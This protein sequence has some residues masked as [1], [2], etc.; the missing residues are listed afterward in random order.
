MRQLLTQFVKYPIYANIVIV[1]LVI[2][3]FI[4]ISN[5]KMAFFPEVE[6]RYISV[7]VYYPG[8]SPQEIEEGITSRI[9]E[10]IR[11]LVGIKEITSTSLENRSNVTI[12]TTGEYPVD[13]V[14]TE[15]KNAVDGISSLPSAAERPL[16]SKRR[17]RSR[18]LTLSLTA[19]EGGEVGLQTLKT[20]AQQVEEDLLR[21][22]VV[23]QLDISGYPAL[24]ISVEIS[25]ENL[26][27]YNLTFSQIAQAISNNNRDLSGGEIRSSKEELLIRLRSRSSDPNKIGSIVV[28]SSGNGKNVYLRDVATVEKKFANTAYKSLRQGKLA[29]SIRVEKLPEEDLQ[30]ID[31]YCRNYIKTFNEKNQGIELQLVSSFL[32]MLKARLDML[33]SNG[34]VGLI[35]VII[36]LALFLS[37]RLSLWVSWGI[38]SAFLAMFIMANLMGVTINMISLFGMIL[39]IGI[40][41]DDGIVIGENIYVHFENGKSPKRAAIDGTM[42]VMPAVVTSISTTIVA[43]S[44]LLF[45]SGRMEFMYEMALVVILCLSF[46]LIE[47]FF[48]LPAHLASHH[49]LSQKSLE[50]KNKGLRKYLQNGFTFL[51]EN[52]YGKFLTYILSW[53]YIV[54]VV[55]IVFILITIGLLSA[56]IITTTFFPAVDSDTFEINIAFT[57][58]TGEETTMKYL[59]RFEQ[60][61]WDLNEELKSDNPVKI[62]DETII[63][64]TGDSIPYIERTHLRL[65]T[66]FSGVENG[67][68]AG[69]IR[70]YPRDMEGTPIG[71]GLALARLL[72]SRIGNIP[73][74]KKFSVAGGNRWGKPVSISV[75]SNNDEQLAKARKIIIDGLE[76]MP[77][78]KDVMDSNAEGKQ[79]VHLQL[80]P[81]AYAL[82]LSE[83]AVANKVRQ[84]FY[85]EQVQRLQEGRDELRVW[86]RYP[87]SNRQRIGQ[88]EQM[89]IQTPAG[90]YPL[91]E[92]AS[93]DIKRGPV[94]IKR[95]N[96]SRE[97]RVEADVLDA[98]TSV[99][100]ILERVSQTITPLIEQQLPNVQIVNQGQQKSSNEAMQQIRKYFGLAFLVMV[101][102]LIIHFKSFQ[103]PLLILLMLPLALLGAAWGHGLHGKPLS[104]LSVWGMVALSGVIVNDAVVFLAKYNS[105]IREG[106]Q[107]KDAI[108]E[109]GKSRLR[110]I[111]LTTLTTSIGL[112]PL[113]METSFQAQ[114]LIPMAISLAYGVAVGTTLTLVFL[115][116]FILAL[117]D[118]RCYTNYTSK[119]LKNYYNTG[120][121]KAEKP[122]RKSVEVASILKE[123]EVI[124]QEK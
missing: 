25:E 15:V 111:I 101:L 65:G 84:A 47:A 117:N 118:V 46:S 21:S 79:E 54:L 121:W 74:A 23:S 58:G 72:K 5:M 57:P 6:S 91:S 49:V 50:Q 68:H 17:S 106:L 82:G 41:V 30:A 4:S 44:P 36:S 94:S 96:G 42:E 53:R 56:R 63:P 110:P 108:I 45:I 71:S 70:I 109:A 26:L 122:Q 38:P 86:V 116:V 107:V 90:I 52:I 3:G 100:E 113:I 32:D 16:I 60:A 83:M 34:I 104:I 1:V 75:L 20:Y 19:S 40:L 92:L 97:V 9:E 67:A 78:L 89:R 28:A 59:T 8:A 31:E 43:F 7:S 95:Y 103:Q 18:T 80:K 37:F 119:L 11:G 102:I 12:E 77:E 73:E 2:G 55:P 24:E 39:V 51:R 22:G 112:F 88:L 14:L 120:E 69:Y 81:L 27:R 87:H 61:V 93:L 99:P 35:L 13:E 115:P 123:Q 64:A 98:K 66:A 33:I 29:V 48:V 114:F 105:L 10:A 124:D 85:G 62:G 76:A